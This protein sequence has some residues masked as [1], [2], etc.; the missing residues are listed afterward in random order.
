VPIAVFMNR[1]T[2][3]QDQAAQNMVIVNKAIVNM[4]LYTLSQD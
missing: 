2:F 1:G 4:R 3:K